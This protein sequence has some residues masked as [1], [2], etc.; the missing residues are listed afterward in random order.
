A[1]DSDNSV[2]ANH[3]HTLDAM[4]FH[5]PRNLIDRRFF[6]DRH[7]LSRHHLLDL[8]TMRMDILVGEPSRT[9]QKLEPA[10]TAPPFSAGFWATQGV[11]FRD[12]ADEVTRIHHR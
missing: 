6:R 7:H 2:V 5:Q 10:R 8:A 4:S 9:K 3:R 1:D 12:D 11:P